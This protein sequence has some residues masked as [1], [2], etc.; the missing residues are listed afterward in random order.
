MILRLRARETDADISWVPGLCEETGG[1]PE[2]DAVLSGVSCICI[3][4]ATCT[5]S[6]LAHL[7]GV[8][9]T[10]ATPPTSSST[11]PID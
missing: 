11:H 4:V 6:R 7:S 1:G 3:T 9:G 2:V 8:I 10:K 5:P